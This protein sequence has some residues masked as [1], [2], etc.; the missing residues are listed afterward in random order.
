MDK[1]HGITELNPLNHKQLRGDVHK[2][3]SR[4]IVERLRASH[5]VAPR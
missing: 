3:N 1:T 5:F 2:S 4:L